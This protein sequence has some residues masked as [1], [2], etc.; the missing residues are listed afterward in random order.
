MPAA[1][2]VEKK[3]V[4]VTGGISRCLVGELA[5]R[6]ARALDDRLERHAGQRHVQLLP[7]R[8]RRGQNNGIIFACL[9]LRMVWVALESARLYVDVGGLAMETF[10]A[11]GVEE[12]PRAR[13]N[14]FYRLK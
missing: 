1:K 10:R 8:A 5:A 14:H 4:E 6:L 11:L 7:P 3:N 9:T 12:R 2:I 13:N